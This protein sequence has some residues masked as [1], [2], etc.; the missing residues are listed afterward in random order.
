MRASVCVCFHTTQTK[1]IDIISTSTMWDNPLS[2]SVG[3]HTHTCVMLDSEHGDSL[4]LSHSSPSVFFL[5][6]L[7]L[8][9]LDLPPAVPPR[10]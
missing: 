9:E 8:I 3:G 4:T 6:N 5:I 10:L 2:W 1:H 7:F